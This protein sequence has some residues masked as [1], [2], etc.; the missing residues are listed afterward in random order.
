MSEQRQ[1]EENPTLS[2]VVPVFNEEENVGP[3]YEEVRDVL[4]AIDEP[5]EILFVNDGSTDETA[6]GLR[7]IQRRDPHLRV[8]DLRGNF[9]EAAALSAG[10]HHSRG[11]FIVTLDG[12]GQNDPADIPRLL[13]VL[14]KNPLQAV[15]GHRVDRQ[16]GFWLRV[17]P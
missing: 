10:F 16:E 2:V 17:L 5:Y 4:E 15:S 14:R 7:E 9:G 6:I 8:L 11:E 13:D 3:L 12:D 1:R